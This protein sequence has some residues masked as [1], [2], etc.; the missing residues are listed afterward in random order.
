MAALRAGRAQMGEP[1]E[2]PPGAACNVASDG[3]ATVLDGGG[4]RRYVLAP[5]SGERGAAQKSANTEGA[6]A[7]QLE[8]LLERDVAPSADNPLR[9]RERAYWIPPG[10][11]VIEAEAALRWKLADV[12]REL[13]AE[14]K[15]KF[16]NLAVFDHR[17]KDT[18]ERPPIV[19]VQWRDWRDE[20]TA[21][22]P[23]PHEPHAPQEPTDDRLHDVFEALH[24]LSHL[25]TPADGLDFALKLLE[26]MVPSQAISACLYDINTD[27]FRFVALSGTGADAMQGH[28]APRTAG[29][30]GIA[31]RAEDHAS[32]FS[33]ARDRPEFDPGVDGRP[34]LEPHHIVYRPLVHEG[35]LMGMLQLVNRAG[36]D[37]FS[38]QD[39]E[40]VEYLARRLAAFLQESRFRR[41]TNPPF[42]KPQGV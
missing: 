15:G 6:P 21:D 24:E 40:L 36:R 20:V 42:P 4:R 8:L 37:G 33:N 11:S 39:V 22:Y 12:Q 41:Q 18:P 16:V 30:L 29:L 23:A 14:P 5:L 2:V 34:G 7:A 28:A 3:V 1:A 31:V 32:V 17:W 27:E 13:A 35:H 26:R 38:P 10:R 9:Y 19:I 25:A